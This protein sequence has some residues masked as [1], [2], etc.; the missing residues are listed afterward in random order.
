MWDNSKK[1][2][3]RDAF[4]QGVKQ[5][6]TSFPMAKMALGNTKECIDLHNTTQNVIFFKVDS[7]L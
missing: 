6:L 5:T 7:L 2:A 4:M 3:G 1:K